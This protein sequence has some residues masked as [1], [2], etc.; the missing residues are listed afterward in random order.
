V[1]E[2]GRRGHP[3]TSFAFSGFDVTVTDG[4]VTVRETDDGD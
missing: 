2:L 3:K 1:R 4:T